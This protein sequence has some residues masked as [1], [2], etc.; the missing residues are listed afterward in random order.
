MTSE[1]L[2]INWPILF[3]GLDIDATWSIFHSTMLQLID[4]Y[5]PTILISP[6]GPRP[7]WMNSA[8]LK[9]VK[10]KRKAWMRYK[11]TRRISDFVAYTK[12]RNLSTTAV[13]HAKY[14]FEKNLAS[15]VKSDCNLFWKYVRSCTKVQSS[16]GA[17]ERGDGILTE[18]D[19]ETANVLNSYFTSVFTKESLFYIPSLTDRSDGNDLS[20][21]AITHQDII[22]QIYKLDPNKSC[23]PDKI[24]PRVIKGTI[25]GLISPLFYIYTKSLHQGSLPASWK[26]AIITPIHKKGSKKVPSNYRPISLTSVF[27]RMLESI[28]KGKIMTYFDTNNLFSEQQHGFRPKMSCVTQ[29]LHVMEY[30]TKI[31]DDG[32]DVDIIYLDFCKAF[33]C[34]PHQRLLSKLKAYGI[35]GSVLNWITDFLSNRRQRVNI[36]GSYSDWSSVTSGV[37][38]GSVLGPL[39]F[40][41]Y[42]NDLPESVQSYTAIFADDTKLYRP[43]INAEDSNILQSD[44]DL[45]IEWCK[46]WLM[47][48]NYSKCKHLPFGHNS[49]SR[50]YTMGSGTALHQICTVDEENDLGIM[51]SRNFKFKSHIHKMVQKANKVL[52][53]INRTFKYLDP[54]IMR[55]LYTSLVRPHLDY[56]SN[57]WNP[58]LLE[59][60]RTIEKLQRRATKLIP[61]LKQCTY[62]ERLSALNLPSLQYRRLRMD[63]IMTYKILQGTVH[64]RKDHFFIMNTNPTRTNGLKIYKHH[65]NKTLRR[66]SF[67]QRIIDHWNRLPSEIVN[68]PNLLSFKTQLDIFLSSLRFKYV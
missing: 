58:Y 40:I 56:A 18:T 14:T 46:V 1:L 31:S 5:V 44:L 49:P 50:H 20:N 62:Q 57:I 23:G 30:W 12:Y 51:F 61:S 7:M 21:M 47:N 11:A 60:M 29:L 36:K 66:Y 17:M 22:D 38:Q 26:D 45:L 59:D 64:L 33:D 53:V 4:K 68:A 27:C 39:L 10:L 54:N 48:F 34:V 52:G 67:S 24:H 55:L 37:P 65:C 15:K 28:I 25:D 16:V 32:N 13:R 3:N 6:S 8:T 41:I 9:A 63:L 43:I 35:A 42:I 2:N 19:Y